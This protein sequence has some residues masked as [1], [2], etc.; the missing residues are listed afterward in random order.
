MISSALEKYWKIFHW[1]FIFLNLRIVFD[2]YFW[3]SFK[4][5]LFGFDIGFYLE[6]LVKYISYEIPL[7]S[8]K[9][10]P[11]FYALRLFWKKSK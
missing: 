7:A 8:F 5:I 2:N 4:N 6:E 1:E 10:I 11:I 9:F 3:Y